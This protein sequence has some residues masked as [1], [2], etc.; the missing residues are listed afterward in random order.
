ML[1]APLDMA[2]IVLLV[3][4]PP[5]V[6]G[7]FAWIPVLVMRG[8]ATL[9]G[10]HTYEFT[11]AVVKIS[12]PGLS[13]QVDCAEPLCREPPRDHFHVGPGTGAVDSRART[14]RRRTRKAAGLGQ[15]S[16]TECR[17]DLTTPEGTSNPGAVSRRARCQR[18]DREPSAAA[19]ELDRVFR[20]R[21]AFVATDNAFVYF[22]DAHTEDH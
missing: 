20:E 13:S 10:T 12:A 8:A 9:Q 4:I 14:E 17:D 11:N 5:L 22:D 16:V 21:P 2:S 1:G 6:A 19:I 3:V 15:A 18:R 7:S